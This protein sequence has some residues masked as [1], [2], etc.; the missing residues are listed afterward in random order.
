MR[1]V[2]RFLVISLLLVAC[3]QVKSLEG[4]PKDTRAPE[5]YAIVPANGTTN[6]KGQA[7]AIRLNEF[8]KLNNPNQTIKMVPNDAKIQTLLKDKTLMVYWTEQLRENTTYSIYFNKTIQD[9]TEQND[10][11]MQYVFSTGDIID[12]LSYTCFVTDALSGNPLKG[13]VVGLFEHA[14]SLSPIYF[15]QTDMTGKAELKYLKEG[16]YFVRAFDDVSKQG[17]IN[18]KNRIAFK[19]QAISIQEQVIDSIPLRMFTPEKKPDVTTFNYQAP[20]SFVIGANRNLDKASIELNGELISADLIEFHDR[21][22]LT[23]FHSPGEENPQQ[24]VVTAENWSDTVKLRIP[25]IKTKQFEAFAPLT[26]FVDG[27]PIVIHINDVIKEIDSSLIQL[28]INDTTFI[29]DYSYTV[30]RNKLFIHLPKDFKS[31][32]LHLL[33]K[34][35]AI[36]ATDGWISQRFEQNFDRKTEKDFGTLN[37]TITGYNEPIIVDV[38][39][40]SKLI[41][42]HIMDG[43]SIL[44]LTQLDPGD[45]HFKITID[46]NN[47]GQWDTGDFEQGL[48]PEEI[49]T[50]STPTKVRANWEVEVE[51]NTLEEKK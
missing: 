17:K 32:K 9:I 30:E 51:L 38:Y 42:Q 10:S 46:S 48:Q 24:L 33:L 22:S 50:Y 16:N 21:D 15:T 39:N 40:R 3:A 43:N 8:V 47:N 34:G 26:D 1:L 18:L 13:M 7:I 27:Q 2:L 23:F 20:S 28:N 35:G 44:Q 11:I 31:N 14:D 6:F 29:S 36:K 45:Y 12:S 4:G 19:G 49:H 25:T 41:A 5:P 37:L